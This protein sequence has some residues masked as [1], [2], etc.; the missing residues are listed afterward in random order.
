[1]RMQPLMRQHTENI[2]AIQSPFNQ[3]NSLKYRNLPGSYCK[4]Q[5]TP[6]RIPEDA[7]N[8]PASHKYAYVKISIKF[9]IQTQRYYTYHYSPPVVYNGQE[10]PLWR[11]P[12][13]QTTHI[14][15][16]PKPGTDRLTELAWHEPITGRAKHLPATFGTDRLTRLAWHQ[17]ITAR[18]IHTLL[19]I[20]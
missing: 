2:Q 8:S 9:G 16:L 5:C 10:D 3:E 11:I 19:Q 20:L 12:G 17:P 4:N 6:E 7:S 15:I 18:D 1:M 13:Q 14:F